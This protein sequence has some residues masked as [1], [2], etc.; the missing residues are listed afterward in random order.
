MM[1]SRL[2][3]FS[4]P[5]CSSTIFR[6]A[7]IV[8]SVL[9]AAIVGLL[10]NEPRRCAFGGFSLGHEPD[11]RTPVFRQDHAPTQRRRAARDSIS[12]NPT[13]ARKRGLI[14]PLRRP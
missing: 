13:L 14:W 3:S 9:G 12:T 10:E 7:A 5:T 11:K 1:P 8:P 4:R 2:C 6:R